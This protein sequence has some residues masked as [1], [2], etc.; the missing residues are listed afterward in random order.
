MIC[1]K[2]QNVMHTV[3]KNGI[4]IE[5]CSGCRGVFLDRGELE[6]IAAAEQQ[7]YGSPP[8]YEGGGG[9]KFRDS[10]PPAQ[11]GYRDSPPPAQRGYRDSPPSY[12]HRG[13]HYDSPPPY[14]HKRRR[15]GFLEGLFD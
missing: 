11:R 9:G 2:C 8:Q 3:D 1:P 13:G 15:G 7:Y 14:G 6:Q 10:P 4:H 12:K 5:Q